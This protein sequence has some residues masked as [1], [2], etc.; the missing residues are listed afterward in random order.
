MKETGKNQ[1]ID[2]LIEEEMRN[3]F[4]Y[5]SEK[6]IADF[7]AA[8]EQMDESDCTPPKGEFERIVAR[9]DEIEA[10]EK[11]SSKKVVRLRRVGKVG[12][13]VAILGCVLMGTG[14]GASG[15]RAY[16]YELRASNQ[17]KSYVWNNTENLEPIYEVEEAY[18]KIKD[19]LG[20]D[21]LRL[22]YIPEKIE[23]SN[24]ILG[25]GYT[26]MD[27]TCD[28]NYIYF[29]Q[30]QYPVENSGNTA[31]DCE[32]VKTVYNKAL[33]LNLLI[34]KNSISDNRVEYFTEFTIDKTYYYL[35]GVISE[36]EF[37]DILIK[38]NH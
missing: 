13:L 14:I 6:L 22:V 4:G 19:E 20:V 28:E 8:A 32:K 26:R 21:V 37:E 12:L 10:E 11:K 24:L 27:F 29:I 18:Q 31:T 16:E 2:N 33:K 23:L 36:E 7:D 3:A 15:K 35:I 34:K 17:G 1:E 30:S 9:V 5:G 25:D 38:I